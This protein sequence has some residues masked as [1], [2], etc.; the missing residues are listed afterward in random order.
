MA[1]RTMSVQRYPHEVRCF[2]ADLRVV[3]SSERTARVIDVAERARPRDLEL[4]FDLWRASCSV[5][6]S[7]YVSPVFVSIAEEAA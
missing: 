5:E 3:R 1:N 4:D 6:D 2:V 7:V